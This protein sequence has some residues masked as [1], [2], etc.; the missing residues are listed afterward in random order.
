[1]VI[2][3]GKVWRTSREKS[4][5]EMRPGILLRSVRRRMLTASNKAAGIRRLEANSTAE[6]NVG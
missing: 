3:S 4:R 5:S 1:M 6:G 2:I